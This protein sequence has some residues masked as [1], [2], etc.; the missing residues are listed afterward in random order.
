MS[1]VTVADALDRLAGM[2]A[3]DVSEE[4]FDALLAEALEDIPPGVGAY[5]DNVALF[6]A[7]DPPPEEA[8]ILG[9]YDGIPLTERDGSFSFAPPDTITLFRNPL[10]DFADD[11]DHLREEIAVTIVH[12]IAHHYGIDDERLHLLGWG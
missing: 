1:S 12:E 2:D 7:D 10:V 4:L 11:V 9:V 3:A 6:V 5:M 8:G